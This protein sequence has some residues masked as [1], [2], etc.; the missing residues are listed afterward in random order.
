MKSKVHKYRG[1]LLML[2]W[3]LHSAWHHQSLCSNDVIHSAAHSPLTKEILYYKNNP[4]LN[5]TKDSAGEE[6][7]RFE[8]DNTAVAIK[9]WCRKSQKGS[10]KKT[11][12]QNDRIKTGTIKMIQAWQMFKN[13]RNKNRG[14][15]MI[16]NRK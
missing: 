9:I 6:W 1:F 3:A 7:T 5:E 16:R 12:L 13:R 8:T 14:D 15:R 4:S 2:S 10:D 11:P